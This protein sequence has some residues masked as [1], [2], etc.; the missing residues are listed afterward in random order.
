MGRAS[1]DLANHVWPDR[2]Q[3]LQDTLSRS[4]GVPILA[5]DPSGRPL[6]A[7]EDLAQFCRRFTRALTIS[8]PCLDCGRSGELQQLPELHASGLRWQPSL[9]QCPLG[10][11]DL[12]S[13]VFCA[14]ETL[15]YLVSAQVLLSGPGERREGAGNLRLARES[16]EHWALLERLPRTERTAMTRTSAGLSA[17]AWLLS[18]LT[19]A[20]KR[21]LRLSERLRGQSRCL[22]EQAITDPVT[23]VANKRRFM[24]ALQAEIERVRRYRRE[25]SLAALEIEALREINE[26]F[27]HDVGD[28]VLSA[29]AHCLTSTLRQTDFIGRTAGSRFSLLLPETAR[30]QALVAVERVLTAVDDLNASGELPV[31]VKLAAGIVDHVCDAPDMLEAAQE[32]AR[33][34]YGLGS[35]VA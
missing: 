3:E 22:R 32:A 7:C 1:E 2:L 6:A 29:V 14:G 21:N 20:R 25:L 9:H 19:S 17:A 30:H 15:G 28:A 24:E 18:A 13:P 33:R 8:R 35:H 12:A 23:G 4:S 11:V 10:P 34:A 16:D 26:E 5:V 31:E 27:G